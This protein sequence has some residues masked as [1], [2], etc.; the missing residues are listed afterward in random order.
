M[1]MTV[2]PY[3][4]P[5]EIRKDRQDAPAVLIGPDQSGNAYILRCARRIDQRVDPVIIYLPY[6]FKKLADELPVVFQEN[7]LHPDI[8][9][10][11]LVNLG[12]L[13][14]R[15]L[16]EFPVGV[17]KIL[18]IEKKRNIR[19]DTGRESDVLNNFLQQG[20]AP[21]GFERG[22]GFTGNAA[23]VPPATGDTG[24]K[25]LQTIARDELGFLEIL[26][27]QKN[28]IFSY[29]EFTD[30]IMGGDTAMQF[31]LSYEF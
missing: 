20:Y 4:I 9:F 8:V 11:D 21:L 15:G 2:I 3:D 30:D 16:I 26:D 1:K 19:A 17:L 22:C 27:S 29:S 13:D 25:K 7:A 31:K 14:T 6:G 10:T 28:L 23:P 18:R 12:I 5:I 24:Y